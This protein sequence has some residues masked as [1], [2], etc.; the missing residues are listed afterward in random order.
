VGGLRCADGLRRALP[1][2]L[3]RRAVPRDLARLLEKRLRGLLLARRL[4]IPICEL[5]GGAA[6]TEISAAKDWIGATHPAPTAKAH[7]AQ[8][9]GSSERESLPVGVKLISL[10]GLGWALVILETKECTGEMRRVV[11][12]WSDWSDCSPV[13]A[14]L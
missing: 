12:D 3:D 4:G 10:L 1:L 14:G 13:M 7:K 11:N 2:P 6:V 8:R 9:N 5:F